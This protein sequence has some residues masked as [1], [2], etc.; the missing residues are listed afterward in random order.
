V[1]AA[2]QSEIVRSHL[3]GEV[4]ALTAQLRERDALI[5]RMFRERQ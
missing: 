2:Q 4:Q 3:E 1:D 5:E